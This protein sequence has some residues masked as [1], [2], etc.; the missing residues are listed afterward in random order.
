MTLA[1]LEPTGSGLSAD[2]LRWMPPLVQGAMTGDFNLYSAITIIDRQNLD[3]ILEQQG[4]SIS[5]HFSEADFIRIGHLANAHYVLTGTITRTPT[6]YM[7][8]FAVTNVQ[9]GVRRASRPPTPVSLQALEDLSA[10]R[11]ASA[12]IL[13]QLGVNL[14]ARGRQELTRPLD[15]SEVHAQ[16]ALARG[17]TAQRQ[18]M[19]AEA[20]SHFIQANVQAPELEEAENRLA[21]L[22]AG[23][24]R[25]DFGVG[26]RQDIAGATS[27]WTVCE[28]PRIFSSVIPS[29]SPTFL[30]TS[31]TLGRG[32]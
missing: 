20:M 6:A 19:E 30:Y 29:D 5:G 12:D 4:L 9:T 8:G 15:M 21:I 18:G 1:I 31:L 7:L 2:E 28:K 3:T 13:G 14:T 26:A 25:T 11:V 16:T 24:A 27:G 10:V 17:I 32:R 23:L 22:T